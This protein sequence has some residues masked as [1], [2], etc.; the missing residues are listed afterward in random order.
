MEAAGDTVEITW[1]EFGSDGYALEST[2]SLD[3]G[4]VWTAVTQQPVE[5]G[6]LKKVTLSIEPGKRFYR[7]AR[8][9]HKKRLSGVVK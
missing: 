2:Q 8:K 4:P 7:L 9:T 5:A 1:R 6:G 3:A